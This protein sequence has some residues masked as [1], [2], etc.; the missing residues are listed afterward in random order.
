[1]NTSEIYTLLA[2]GQASPTGP[3][4]SSI[5]T[6]QIVTWDDLTGVNS[7]FVNGVTIP[8][9]RVVQSGLGIGYQPGDVVKIQRIMTQ[10][11]IIGKIGAPGAGAAQQIA[12]TQIDTYETSGAAAYVALPTPGPIVSAFIGSSRRCLVT[13]SCRISAGGWPGSAKYIGGFMGFQVGGAS[14]IA[15]ADS[16]AVGTNIYCAAA[17]GSG[18]GVSSGRTLLLTAADGLNQGFN[19]FTALYSSDDAT[20]VCGFRHRNITVIPL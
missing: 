17:P 10:Y 5:Y 4:D 14:A 8:N 18:I 9:L 2:A 12:S 20:I 13:L 1:M 11:Y 15:A 19:V 16:R 3:E 7:V 6:G